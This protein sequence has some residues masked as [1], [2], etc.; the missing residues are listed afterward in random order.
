MYTTTAMEYFTVFGKQ[1][2][3]NVLFSIFEEKFAGPHKI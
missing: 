1:I 3:K 2:K